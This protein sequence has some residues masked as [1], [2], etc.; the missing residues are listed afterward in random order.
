MAR[1]IADLEASPTV[2]P[3]H[4]N[5]AYCGT[6]LWLN[7]VFIVHHVAHLRNSS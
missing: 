5:E 3:H 6:I 1:T 4:I 2:Q 7:F